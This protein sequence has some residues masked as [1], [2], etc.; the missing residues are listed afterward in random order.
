M[1][2]KA[3]GRDRIKAHPGIGKLREALTQG[4]G[5]LLPLGMGRLSRV[6]GEDGPEQGDNGRPLLGGNMSQSVPE[7]AYKGNIALCPR[8]R[9]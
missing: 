8:C 9:P 7:R 4:V 3:P 6:L 1:Q 5:H 2:S